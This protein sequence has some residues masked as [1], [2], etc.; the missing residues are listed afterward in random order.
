MA[1]IRR[2]LKLA[3]ALFAFLLYVWYA[4][5]QY[6]PFVKRRKARRRRARVGPLRN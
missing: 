1:R 6:A 3:G 4:A 5:V 2:L